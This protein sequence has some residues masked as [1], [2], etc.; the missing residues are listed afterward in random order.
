MRI[1]VKV[2]PGAPRSIVKGTEDGVL[3]VDIAAPAEGNKA[4]I[5]L[6]K[7]LKR[8]FKRPCRL[9]SGTTSRKKQVEFDES[10]K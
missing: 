5:E 4:N 10:N 7:L 2:R 1:D 8:H 3:I 6:L 9:V